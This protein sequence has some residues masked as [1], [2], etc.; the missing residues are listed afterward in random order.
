ML[1]KKDLINELNELIR[2]RDR[3]EESNQLIEAAV[4]YFEQ[5]P[6][7]IEDSVIE[8]IMYRMLEGED[9][10]FPVFGDWWEQFQLFSQFEFILDQH[11]FKTIT[12]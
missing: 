2:A 6:D 3:H 11:S 7:V 4:K 9:V 1:L 8:S 12:Y 10:F 5:F